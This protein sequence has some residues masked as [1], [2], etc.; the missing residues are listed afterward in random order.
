[1][2]K[3]NSDILLHQPL[4]WSTKLYYI[5]SISITISILLI[6][7]HKEIHFKIHQLYNTYTYF[8]LFTFLLFLYWIYKQK[9]FIQ[10]KDYGKFITK[11][12]IEF[13][14]YSIAI[15]F[16]FLPTLIILDISHEITNKYHFTKK[17]KEL[18]YYSFKENKYE[19]R[20]DINED[21]SFQ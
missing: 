4:L 6:Q 19:A 8:L 3:N 13:Q 17:E 9:Y 11:P 5:V 15:F 16:F 14:I 10:S 12:W 7:Y 1:M 21:G 20:C 2:K 18:L